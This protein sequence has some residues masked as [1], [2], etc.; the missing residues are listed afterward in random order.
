[1]SN[2]H[3]R[4]AVVGAGIGGLTVAAALA[5]N[6]LRCHVFEQTRLLG[7]VGAGVQLAPNATRLLHRLGLE[8]RLRD[9]AVR[10]CAIE[11][12]RWEDNSV[13]RRTPMGEQCEQY[14]GA[15]YY[16]VHRADLHH[17]L[18][19]RLSEGILHLG[20]RCTGV[21]EPPD[22][23][24]LQFADGS[25]TTADLV[26]GADG[27]HSR[28]RDL[29]VRDEPQ[30]SGQSIYRALVPAERVP[31]LLKEPKVVLWL[32]PGKHCVSYP[33]SA[34]DR[35]SLAATVPDPHWGTESW[36]VQGRTEDLA[37]A[38]ADWNSEVRALTSAPDTVS[39]WALHDRDSPSRWSTDRITLIGDA[40]HP[41]LP[42]LAQGANQ[43]IEDAVALAACLRDASPDGVAAALARWEAAR[44]SR[45]STVHRISRANTTV[46]HLPDGDA[47][48]RRDHALAVHATL[49][50]QD[51]IYGYDAE[52]A[53]G[54]VTADAQGNEEPWTGSKTE[55]RS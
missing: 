11:M 17:C 21:Q 52:A 10:P 18:L 55:S 49:A 3:I 54:I 19:E 8:D 37:G 45:I 43:A 13:L 51:W 42:F 20:L 9:V 44:R 46:M 28:V 15:P 22:D 6:G 26:V 4:I 40:A 32:G 7:E 27:I 48:R 38:Y 30:Y 36:S 5:R 50:D 47:Q 2:E 1:V 41:M 16:T 53:V 24:Q 25:S 35:I 12:R 39:R 23:V 33:V 14:F 34:G 31:F 29:L